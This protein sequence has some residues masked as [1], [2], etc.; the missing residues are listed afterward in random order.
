[1]SEEKEQRYF[2]VVDDNFRKFPNNVIVKPI[3]ATDG[4]AGYDFFSNEDVQLGPGEEHKFATDIKCKMHKD[5]Q[6]EII[7][8][9]GN[10]TNNKIL[11]KNGTG[12]I[13]SDYYN[14]PKNDGNI[15]I[16][17]VNEGT[18]YFHVKEGQRIAQGTFTKYLITD[19][20]VPAAQSR[21]G[22]HGSTGE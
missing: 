1:M 11:L 14:N 3:R 17:L 22:G 9:S 15:K 21:D 18:S 2:E 10:G 4:S 6:L 16:T 20:D 5:D 19:D 7:T 13:D 12:K 8:R